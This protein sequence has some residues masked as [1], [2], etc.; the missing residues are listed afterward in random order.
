MGADPKTSVLNRF[1]QAHEVKNLFVTDAGC[2]T[3]GPDK[4]PT[5]NI[6][7]LSWRA[8]EYALEQARKNNL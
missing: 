3:T 2:F 5:L 8:A 1:C 7:A 6:L 4:N